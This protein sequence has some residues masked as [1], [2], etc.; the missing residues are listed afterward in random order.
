[1][2][3]KP[4]LYIVSTPIGNLGDITI[5]AI[6]TLQNSSVILCEDTRVSQKL[7]AKHNIKARL[8]AYND[9]STAKQRENMAESIANGAVVSLISDAGTPL[10]SDPGYKLVKYLKDQRLLVEIVPGVSAPIAA[11]ILSGLASDRFLFAGFLP[12][13]I[14][15]KRKIF[16]EMTKINATLIFFETSTR[17]LL[18]L[19]I[20][21]EVFGNR[22]AC[23]ARELTKLY[24]E[25]NTKPLADLI[26]H[27]TV[28]PP[29][30]ELV[31]LISGIESIDPVDVKYNIEKM[32]ISYLHSG[33][34]KKEATELT[35]KIYS[36][37]CSKKEIYK[38][39]NRLN[40]EK[41]HFSKSKTKNNKLAD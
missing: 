18:S 23:V 14:E 19:S 31:L 7:L 34:S 33:A 28:K 11:L 24:Q 15:A 21:K 6:D 36:K 16:V 2:P 4:G 35:Y 13:T 10:I 27:Y 25:A 40:V 5:R 30:G 3:L 39:A 20:A 38:M 29:K 8:I 17:L 37:Y 32:L 22:E 41:L 1:M 9:H 26:D 12:K